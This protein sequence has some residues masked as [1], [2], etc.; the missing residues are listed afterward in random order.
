MATATVTDLIEKV[1]QCKQS[2]ATALTFF[3]DMSDEPLEGYATIISGI[4]TKFEQMIAMIENFK[5]GET[6][7]Y[8]DFP[9]VIEELIDALDDIKDALADKGYNMQNYDITEYAGLIDALVI[10]GASFV[11]M[12]FEGVEQTVYFDAM[13][14]N[15]KGLFVN[16]PYVKEAKVVCGSNTT[17]LESMFYGCT[18][19]TKAEI[20]NI[21][22]GANLSYLFKNCSALNSVKI[23]IPQNAIIT[24][25]FFNCGP[26]ADENNVIDLTNATNLDELFSMCRATDIKGIISPSGNFSARGLVGDFNS[27][28]SINMSIFPEL[29]W[30][31]CTDLTRAFLMSRLTSLEELPEK[32][33]NC[34]SLNKAFYRC[35]RLVKINDDN[36]FPETPLLANAK[37]LFGL[38]NNASVLTGTLIFPDLSLC[39]NIAYMF[40]QQTGITKVILRKTH[41]L[42]NLLRCFYNCSNLQEIEIEDISTAITAYGL[43]DTDEYSWNQAFYN[44]QNLKKLK[45]G[46]EFNV[47]YSHS[48][49][50]NNNYT[51]GSSLEELYLD[52]VNKDVGFT[53][54]Q[55]CPVLKKFYC[56]K[57]NYPQIFSATILDITIDGDLSTSLTFASGLTSLAI[58]GELKVNLNLSPCVNMTAAALDAFFTG[59][60]QS[61]MTG[62][63][64]TITGCA[65]AAT[66]DTS[67][68]TAK[69]YTVV[70][71]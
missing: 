52:T 34:V 64:I 8:S 30:E 1:D 27:D 53:A 28:S 56:K 19:L 23:T 62:I 22:N 59:L 18:A 47:V 31:N 6:V 44:C 70:N 9:N 67:I 40:Y 15:V 63:T 11:K 46:G 58:N 16:N 43:N 2:I 42:K 38:T 61:T 4:R 12:N 57:I 13:T 21:P 29:D 33:S 66:C 20:T 54:T 51:L 48:S 7:D 60:D 25:M 45:M 10:G 26:L 69:G 5:P 71:S 41:S 17:D 55:R 39:N 36:V 32:L 37:Y 14:S 35:E 24:Q 50:E 68:A 49:Y 65:G 3:A